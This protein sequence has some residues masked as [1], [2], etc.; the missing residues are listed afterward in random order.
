[1][2]SFS[3]VRQN[4]TPPFDQLVPYVLAM[5]DLEE[6]VRMMGNVLDIAVDDVAIGLAVTVD[7]V[8]E[9]DDVWLPMWRPAT[10]AQRAL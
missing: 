5:I 1:V 10:A 2:Y 7:F 3:I 4:G 9:T 6:G 8:P